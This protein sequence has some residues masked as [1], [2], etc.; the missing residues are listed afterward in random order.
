MKNK[1]MY[2]LITTIS[3][4]LFA[5]N[6]TPVLA[7]VMEIEVIGGGYHLK[8]PETLTF[9]PVTAQFS[10]QESTINIRNTDPDIDEEYLE[11]SDENGGRPF[12]VSVVSDNFE[13]TSPAGNTIE[14]S[15]FEIKNKDDNGTTTDLDPQSGSS[16]NIVSLNSETDS[17]VSLD[18]SR[19]LFDGTGVAPGIW[20]IYPLLRLNIPSGTP[21]GVYNTVIV[22]TV[23]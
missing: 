9:A 4:G 2:K 17:Y 3:L 10:D 7:Q 6:F 5:L 22:F 20:R 21:P 18:T 11:I 1:S 16:S 13:S 12:S 19:L 23:T 15:N 8:G 14:A